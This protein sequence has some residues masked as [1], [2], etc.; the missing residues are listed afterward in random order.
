[1]TTTPLK[2]ALVGANGMLAAAI[3][4]HLPTGY[5]LKGYDLPDFDLTDLQQVFAL[6][7]DVPDII[8]NCAAFTNVDGCEEQTELAM[9]VNGEG[10]GLLAELAQKIDA[11]LVHIS[12][13]FVFAG[14]KK[15]PYLEDDQTQPLS[16]YG[17][18]KLLGEQKIQQS[19]LEEYFIVRTSWLY[20]AGA[21][22]S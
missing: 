12:T 19:G 3:K 5:D 21:T 16:A 18:S 17:K 7:Q 22:I 4:K 14:N 15:T 20:G 10:P 9:R 6:Q 13:D 8:I 11:L 1:M 2:I